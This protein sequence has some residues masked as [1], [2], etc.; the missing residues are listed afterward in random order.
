MKSYI[1]SYL[2]IKVDDDFANTG[3]TDSQIDEATEYIWRR[4]DCSD[5]YE[6]VDLLLKLFLAQK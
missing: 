3:L 5:F 4:Y 1:A 6:Q 2:K